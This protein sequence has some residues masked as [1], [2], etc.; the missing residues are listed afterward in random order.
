[1]SRAAR[2]VTVFVVGCVLYALQGCASVVTPESLGWR[3]DMPG[4]QMQR[5]E[6]NV[7][8]GDDART[9]LQNRCGRWGYN[10]LACVIRIREGGQCVAFSILTEE[11]AKRFYMVHEGQSLHEHELMHCGVVNGV[12]TGSGWAHQ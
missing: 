9:R 10:L 8:T 2:I 7:I 3:Q 6:W 5:L 12:S 4:F 11:E 1:M